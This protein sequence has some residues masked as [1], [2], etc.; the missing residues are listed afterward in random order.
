[1]GLR[2]PMDS[3]PWV[4]VE[5]RVPF[6]ELDPMA[7]RG[8]LPSRSGRSQQMRLPATE[9]GAAA[10][11]RSA[12]Q[13]RQEGVEYVG[14]NG[15][16]YDSYAQD[17]SRNGKVSEQPDDPRVIRTALCVEPRHGR[18]HVFLHPCGYWKNILI[19]SLPWRPPLRLSACRC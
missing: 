17:V 1:M 15:I 14:R 11:F 3:L 5:E 12:E 9:Y 13:G 16:P 2:L 8:P 6:H 18:L 10:I 4:P 7:P 19:W